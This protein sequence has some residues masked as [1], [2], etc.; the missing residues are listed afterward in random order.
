MA[1]NIPPHMLPPG[2]TGAKGASGSP[3][4]GM[5]GTDFGAQLRQASGGRVPDGRALDPQTLA[6]LGR[7]MQQTMGHASLDMLGGDSG[8]GGRGGGVADLMRRMVGQRPTGDGSGPAAAPAAG[9]DQGRPGP[10][11]YATPRVPE[12]GSPAADPNREAPTE[13]AP[14]AGDSA[15]KT[16][17][18]AETGPPDQAVSGGRIGPGCPTAISSARPATASAW[19]RS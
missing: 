9:S 16:G 6:R 1:M 13:P 7:M 15:E 12:G 18:S 17:G 11:G 2:L 8:G 3:G 10:D 14:E 4:R 5:P 19:T